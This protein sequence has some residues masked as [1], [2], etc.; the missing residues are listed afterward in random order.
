MAKIVIVGAGLTGLSAAYHLEKKGFF[1][2]KLFEKDS[3]TGGLC[4]SVNQDGFIFDYTGHLLHI[5]DA[6][7]QSLVSNVV[8]MENFHSIIRRSFIYSHDVYTHYPFQINLF[9]L[10]T[11]IIAECIEGFVLKKKAKKI[12]SFYDWALSNFGAGIAR[13]FFFPFQKKIFSYN[14]KKVTASWTGRFVPSTSLSEMIHGALKD[15]SL[16]QKVGYNAHFYYPKQGGIYFWVDKIAQNLKNPIF[17]HYEV[18]KIDLKNKV[19]SFTNG[20]HE[21]FDVL[22]STMPLDHCL[23]KLQE[24][25]TTDFAQQRFNLICNSVTNFNLGF[26]RPDVSDKHW[27]YFPES[28]FPFYRVGFP[29]NFAQGAVPEGCSSLYG[30]FSYINKTKTFNRER[31]KKSLAATKKLFKIENKDIV[32]EKIIQISHAYVI[33]DF[34]RE[35]HLTKLLKRLQEHDLHSIGRYGA[36]KY[37]SM[38]EAVLDGKKIAEE[39]TVMPAKK[40]VFVTPR[41][42]IKEKE[43]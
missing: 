30:E 20:E 34:W 40:E 11:E 19:V 43:L 8:G 7:L 10:P 42:Y 27:I 5:S 16:D 26:S 2:Y 36:W 14:L 4:R 13:H 37:S 23:E 3:T 6:Y 35:K 41:D 12:D 9:G 29:H 18:E 22:I 21:P 33:Y 38:Q 32:T 17:T 15:P 25:S 28:D 24:K 1:D 31:L 39:L